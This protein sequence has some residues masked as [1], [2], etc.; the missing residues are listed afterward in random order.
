MYTFNI[1]IF[2]ENL[3]EV[4]T[5]KKLK[6]EKTLKI[7]QPIEK[8]KEAIKNSKK[9]EIHYVNRKGERTIRVIKPEKIEK[10]NLIAYCYLRNSWRNFKINR[11][12]KIRMV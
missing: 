7:E 2:G 10:G 8:I 6:K 11:I 1:K 5:N 12:E 9:I 3:L 4:K